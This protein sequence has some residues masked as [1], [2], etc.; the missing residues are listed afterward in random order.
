MYF[1][2]IKR[3]KNEYEN[4]NNTKYIKRFYKRYYNYK[5]ET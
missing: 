4:K 2:C 3:I 5:C 1:I